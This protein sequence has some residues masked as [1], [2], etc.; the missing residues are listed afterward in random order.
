ML[1]HHHRDPFD[2]LI[3]AQALELRLPIVSRDRVFDLYGVTRIWS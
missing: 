1:P 2:R 3:A